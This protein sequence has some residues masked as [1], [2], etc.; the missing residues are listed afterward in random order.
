MFTDE[1]T[2]RRRGRQRSREVH[3]AIL[4][5]TWELL[6]K[7]SLREVTA[8]AIAQRAGVSKA[9]LYK[10]WANKNLIAVDAFEAKMDAMVAMP[11]TGS[12]QQ[13]FLEQ[14]STAIEFYK[15]WSGG[16]IRQFIAEGQSD[17]EF[18]A[19]FRER[20]INLLR[21]GPRR[22]WQRG[23]DRGQIRADV[24]R[25]LFLDLIY[26]PMIYRLLVGCGPLDHSQATAIINLV[27]HAVA[28]K[29]P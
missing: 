24:D 16:I 11:D 18:L 12:A 7:Q 26:G 2:P 25:E 13:D 21:E 4:T 27:F 22:M 23:V 3:D 5:A 15:S 20:F 8:D 17:P 28:V 9:T 19:T 29:K 6:E 10:W 1:G 14:F